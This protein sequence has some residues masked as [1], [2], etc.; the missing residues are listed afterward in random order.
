RS[1][2]IK[3]TELIAF[4]FSCYNLAPPIKFALIVE[5]P[6]D[7]AMARCRPKGGYQR[8]GP[9]RPLGNQPIHHLLIGLIGKLH[10]FRVL[11]KR[12]AWQCLKRLARFHRARSWS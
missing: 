7:E 5:K 3:Q 9:Q 4:R 12:Y 1:V 2:G 6:I 8:L 10:A 11:R